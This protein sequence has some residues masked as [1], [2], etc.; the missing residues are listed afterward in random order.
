[1][2]DKRFCL[3]ATTGRTASHFI[4]S[5]LRDYTGAAVFHDELFKRLRGRKNKVQCL[6]NYL[7]NL[8]A[9]QPHRKVYVE[10]NGAFLEWVGLRYSIPDAQAVIPSGL[11]SHSLKSILLVRHPWGYVKS[12]KAQGWMWNWQKM[13]GFENI[14]CDKLLWNGMDKISRYAMAW[15]MKNQFFMG[16]LSSGDC[17]LVKFENLFGHGD[18]RFLSTIRGMCDHL[19]LDLGGSDETLAAL[20]HKKVAPKSGGSVQLTP[21]EKRKVK[22]ICKPV[23]DRFNYG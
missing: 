1:M 8:Q 3:I 11:L 21:A 18:A 12:M 17:K 10:C 7:V 9:K 20:R 4:A 19:G 15:K 14:Y 2:L 23:M 22:N 13:G 5:L 16:L 6:E